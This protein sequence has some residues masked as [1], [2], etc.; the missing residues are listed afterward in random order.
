VHS[1]KPDDAAADALPHCRGAGHADV[2]VMR[3]MKA[4]EEIEPVFGA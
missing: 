3:T 4:P 1:D 2:I